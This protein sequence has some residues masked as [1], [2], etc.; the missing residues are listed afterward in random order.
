MFEYCRTKK[1]VRQ[2]KSF[3]VFHLTKHTVSLSEGV[4]QSYS[5]SIHVRS[6][7]TTIL[8]DETVQQ[9]RVSPAKATSDSAGLGLHPVHEVAGGRV[10]ANGYTGEHLKKMHGAVAGPS[11]TFHARAS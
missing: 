11:E 4:R 5:Q 1:T 6:K 2:P 9:V 10:H 3:R 7:S 8:L